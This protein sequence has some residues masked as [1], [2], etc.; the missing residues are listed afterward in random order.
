M[1]GFTKLPKMQCFKE[2]GAVAPVTKKVAKPKS[3]PAVPSI[4]KKDKGPAFPISAPTE[5]TAPDPGAPMMKKGGRAKKEVG[6]VKK[7]KTGGTVENQYGAKKTDK[8]IKDIANSKRQKPVKL[9]GG[10]KMGKYAD[11]GV[12]EAVKGAA[13]KLKENIIGTP[14]QNKTAQENMDKQAQAG[15]KLATVLGGNAKK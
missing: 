11:G 9:C 1:E 5:D 13:T 10:G 4:S 8:D 3:K 14:E 2:G 12:V 7:Y 15:S 6:T